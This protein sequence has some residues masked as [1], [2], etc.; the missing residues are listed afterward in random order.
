MGV[1][2]EEGWVPAFSG[3]KLKADANFLLLVQV[4]GVVTPICTILTAKTCFQQFAMCCMVVKEY[5]RNDAILGRVFELF[6][7]DAWLA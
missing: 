6:S 1:E 5:L 7:V 2:A 4:Q 3:T